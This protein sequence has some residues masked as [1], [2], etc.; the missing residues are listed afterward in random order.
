MPQSNRKYVVVVE[1]LTLQG[2]T[3]KRGHILSSEELGPMARRLADA[4]LIRA[5][6]DSKDEPQKPK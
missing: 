6:P 3:H 1:S 4:G 5:V 2:A